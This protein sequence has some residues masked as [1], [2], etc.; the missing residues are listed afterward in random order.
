M[1]VLVFSRFYV[2]A[3]EAGGPT[4]TLSDL[5]SVLGDEI[6]FSVVTLDHGLSDTKPYNGVKSDSWNKVCSSQIL[7]QTNNRFKLG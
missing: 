2:P 5:V 4:K 6:E 7:E 1:K 3:F